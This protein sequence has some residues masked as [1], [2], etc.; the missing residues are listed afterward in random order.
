MR[1]MKPCDAPIRRNF[2]PGVKVEYSVSARQSAY[3]VQ[4]NRIQVGS[5][6]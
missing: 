4:I 1:M 5:R 3:R 6:E 2:L